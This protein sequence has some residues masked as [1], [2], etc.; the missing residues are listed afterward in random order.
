MN[1]ESDPRLQAIAEIERKR[2]QNANSRFA[3]SAVR[4]LSGFDEGAPR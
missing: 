2:A 1:G 3:Q 4:P